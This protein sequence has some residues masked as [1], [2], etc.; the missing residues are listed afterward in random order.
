M[1]RYMNMPIL[2]PFILENKPLTPTDRVK[3]SAQD[4]AHTIY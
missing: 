4:L 1:L 3:T 2:N